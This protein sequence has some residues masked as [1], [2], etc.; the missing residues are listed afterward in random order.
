MPDVVVRRSRGDLLVTVKV[1]TPKKVTK[2]QRK[3]LE[4]LAETL[5]K[6]KFRAD[7]A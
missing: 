3:L 2:E 5:P 1:V 6:E 7:A 4:Q